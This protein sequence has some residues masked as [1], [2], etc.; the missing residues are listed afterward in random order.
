MREITNQLASEGFYALDLGAAAAG[1]LFPASLRRAI[2]LVELDAVSVAVR[3]RSAYQ[4]RIAIRG[5][6]A[7]KA[8]TRLFHKRRFP[9]VSS[10]L[11]PNPELV[12]AYGIGPYYEPDGTVELSCETLRTVLAS[13]NIPRVD[14]IKTDLEG[15]DYEVLS[16]APEVV[17]QAV[18]IQSELR[19]EPFYIGEPYFHQ[20]AEFMTGLGFDLVSMRPE[21][22]KPVTP[23]STLLRDGRLVWADVIWFLGPRKVTEVFREKSALAFTKQII[24]A[25]ALGLHCYA[26]FIF[27]G[28]K[29]SLPTAPREELEQFLKPRLTRQTALNF[30]G[31]I[32]AALPRGY[33]VLGIVRRNAERVARAASVSHLKQIGSL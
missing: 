32:V 31:N 23:H 33:S 18:A 9:P 19:F 6:V 2:T 20:A 24:L 16:S 13:H 28:I 8:G 14:F 26:E 10:F 1:E 30:L 15:L 27:V 7:G 12:R 21:V 11:E 5:G 17:C 22:W 4:H 3:D 25:K 29:E